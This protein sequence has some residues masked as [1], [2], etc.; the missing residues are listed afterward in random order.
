MWGYDKND[1]T[2][3]SVLGRNNKYREIREMLKTDV[4][5]SF[6]GKHLRNKNKKGKS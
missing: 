6:I 2:S 1:V 3:E 5:Q 4:L